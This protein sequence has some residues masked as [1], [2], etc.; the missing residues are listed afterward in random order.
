LGTVSEAAAQRGDEPAALATMLQHL[1]GVDGESEVLLRHTEAL[2]EA[3]LA[4]RG[5]GLPML[6][7]GAPALLD[8]VETTI[9]R[10]R[11]VATVLA[12]ATN[13][14]PPRDRRTGP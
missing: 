13:G 4:G 1:A 6:T 9:R 8:G 3:L 2:A 14:A 5:P 10:L 12:L 11:S 7:D